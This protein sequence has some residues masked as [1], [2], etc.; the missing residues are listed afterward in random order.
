[1][2]DFDTQFFNLATPIKINEGPFNMNFDNFSPD[3]E[4]ISKRKNLTQ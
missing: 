4:K 1:M 3:R 2:E